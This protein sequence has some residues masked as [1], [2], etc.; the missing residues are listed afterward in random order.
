MKYSF[1]SYET[2]HFHAGSDAA[3]LYDFG[4]CT[5]IRRQNDGTARM[6]HVADGL[7]EHFRGAHVG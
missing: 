1:N 4:R 5:C 2:L 6:F 3:V 7:V